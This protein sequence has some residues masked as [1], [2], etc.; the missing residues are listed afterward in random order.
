MEALANQMQIPVDY[1]AVPFLV[2]LG[3][4][5]GR[6]RALHLR[7]GTHWTEHANLW[8][9]I[10]GRPSAMKSPAM[11]AVKKPLL[12]LTERA[13]EG[14]KLALEQFRK[15]Q[16]AWELRSKVNKEMYKPDFDTC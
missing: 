7:P 1:L 11:Q 5:I 2:Y 4:L 15:D 13:N 10:I 8:G 6:K 3:S 12:A 9:M 16:E 14:Y